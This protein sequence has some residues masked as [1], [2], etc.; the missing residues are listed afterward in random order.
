MLFEDDFESYEL[1]EPLPQE[2]WVDTSQNI[3]NNV[4][5]RNVETEMF[6]V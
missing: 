1:N 2:K 5:V 6:G 4:E 3:N